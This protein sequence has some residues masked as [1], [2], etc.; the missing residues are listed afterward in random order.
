MDPV[1]GSWPRTPFSCGNP[2]DNLSHNRALHPYQELVYGCIAHPP[3]VQGKPL[4]DAIDVTLPDL[5][6][7]YWRASLELANFVAPYSKMDLPTPKPQH[8]DPTPDP[9]VLARVAVLGFPNLQVDR[10][11]GVVNVRP[12]QSATGTEIRISNVGSGIVPWKVS[13]NKSWVTVSQVAGV[14]VGD[15]LP[16]SR[17]APCERTAVLKISADPQKVLGTDAAVVRIEGLG[18]GGKTIEV[19]IFVRVNVAIGI[20]G[21][22]KN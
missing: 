17:N 6:N 2:S 12:G 18:H 1:Y 22:A 20:P 9:G 13:A 8:E 4:W 5:N 21:T 14:A 16:C 10:P 7:P 15:N 11:I 3:L 19:A